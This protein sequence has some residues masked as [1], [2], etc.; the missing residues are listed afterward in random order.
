[1]PDAP[2]KHFTAPIMV[3]IGGSYSYVHVEIWEPDA[4][5]K[6]ICLIHDIAGRADDFAPLCAHLARSGHRVVALD[7]PGRG[8]SA[9]I[10]Q[11]LYTAQT[12]VQ[13][14]LAALKTHGL[15][16]TALLGQGWGAMIAVL[17]D[18]VAHRRFSQLYLLDL[19][20]QWAFEVDQSAQTWSKLAHIKSPNKSAFLKEI[21]AAVPPEMPGRTELLDLVVERARLVDGLYGLNVDPAI[22]RHLKEN[23]DKVYDL[24]VALLSANAPIWLFSGMHSIPS[25][26]SH[27]AR[28]RSSQIRHTCVLR[29]SNQSWHSD[30]ILA[31]VLGAVCMLG[32]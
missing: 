32:R 6:A 22:F 21:D 17:L 14:L 31:P 25:E 11:D 10:P 20:G 9:W 12:Y 4:P 1:M 2:F 27:N 18:R 29:A 13:V 23:S 16:N 15:N 3:E 24:D 8:N 5:D 28:E 19:P 26:R 7:L 30:D